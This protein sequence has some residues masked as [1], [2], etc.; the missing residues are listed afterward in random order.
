MTKTAIFS[1][2]HRDEYKGKRPVAAAW[3]IVAPCGAIHS[4]HSLDL[5]K[6]RKTADGN[7]RF[8]PGAPAR[9]DSPRGCRYVGLIQYWNKLARK[10]GFADWNAMYADYE[11]QMAKFRAT[12]TV[13]VVAI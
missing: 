7:V 11:T 13:E 5:I 1:N 4:G 3:M 2:G 12:C 8:M 6:A 10:A 9:V